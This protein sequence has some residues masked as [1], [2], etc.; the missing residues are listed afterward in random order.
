MNQ[1]GKLVEPEKHAPALNP[2]K[3]LNPLKLGKPISSVKIVKP[4]KKPGLGGNYQFDPSSPTPDPRWPPDRQVMLGPITEDLT[5]LHSYVKLRQLLHG[6]IYFF[7][8]ICH[9]FLQ[10]SVHGEAKTYGYVVFTDKI[11]AKQLFMSKVVFLAGCQ[12]QV[13]RMERTSSQI[14]G[15]DKTAHCSPIT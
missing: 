9:F 12:V 2:M 3:S 1:V 10:K 5:K 7:G 6:R 4:V 8:K 14:Q 13:S 15:G 11:S